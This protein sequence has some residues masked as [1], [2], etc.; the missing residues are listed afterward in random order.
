MPALPSR[1]REATEDRLC[2][3][4]IFKPIFVVLR[5]LTAYE[6]RRRIWEE[7]NQEPDGWHVFEGPDERGQ[8]TVHA[9]HQDHVW[10]LKLPQ[11]GGNGYADKTKASPEILEQLRLNPVL[12]GFKIVSGRAFRILLGGGAINLEPVSVDDAK[13]RLS[14]PDTA[15]LMV[16][17]PTLVRRMRP[18]FPAQARLEQRLNEALQDLRGYQ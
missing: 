13:K 18:L 5:M 12:F 14:R 7:Y 16:V 1:K 9:Y 11:F 2:W 15:G 3:A 6:A 10:V 4:S 8:L 17:R